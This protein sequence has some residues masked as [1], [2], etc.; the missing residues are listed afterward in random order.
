MRM[1]RTTLLAAGF[2]AASL[3]MAPA[4]AAPSSQ[5]KTINKPEIVKTLGE[6]AS[7]KLYRDPAETGIMFRNST[8]S[9][10]TI[11]D[12]VNFATILLSPG[13]QVGISAES[14]RHF[15]ITLGDS[16]IYESITSGSS[17]RFAA[18]TEVE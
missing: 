5:T 10:I 11:Q 13:D 3:A 9:M 4:I 1:T 15:A 18:D 2:A 7:M 8:Q 6:S 14:S 16:V 17:I 12:T